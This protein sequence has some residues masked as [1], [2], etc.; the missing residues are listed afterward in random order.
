MQP[1]QNESYVLEC[2]ILVT[3]FLPGPD[4]PFSFLIPPVED[5]EETPSPDNPF[6]FLSPPFRTRLLSILA[7]VAESD[8]VLNLQDVLERFTF[9]NVCKVAFN[10]D[11]AC[12]VGDGTADSEFM[13][14]FEDVAA[15]SLWR[16]MSVFPMVWKA[17]KRLNVGTERKLRESISTVHQFANAN[18]RS[19]LKS[20][21][22]LD[23]SVNVVPTL[24]E[25]MRRFV[26]GMSF[27]VDKPKIWNHQLLGE[28]LQQ[29]RL[30]EEKTQK[31]RQKI[32]Q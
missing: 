29:M 23:E 18:I 2:P 27:D 20:V 31:S 28:M 19:R 10:V 4:N 13:R 11:P 26:Q 3:F 24:Q 21:T 17:K 6:S 22:C 15:L 1:D 7:S 14:T 30:K 25:T 5:Y 9:D 8:R 16:F 12:L 32:I